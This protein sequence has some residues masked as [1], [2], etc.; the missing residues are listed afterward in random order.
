M[1]RR[2]PVIALLGLLTGCGA[3]ETQWIS[4]TGSP[5]VAGVVRPSGLTPATG[6]GLRG[7]L[8]GTNRDFYLVD[9]RSATPYRLE[10]DDRDALQMLVGELVDA[11]GDRTAASS[12]GMQQFIVRELT[13]VAD[14]CPAE[15]AGA[16]N[17]FTRP[18]GAE[19]G[20]KEV[21]P[22]HAPLGAQ[23]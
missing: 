14:T 8:T 4:M 15:L 19:V 6:N 10:A 20:V 17:Q 21:V 11:T 9:S 13:K 12:S 1:P 16:V 2:I 3:H 23:P 18:G 5:A 22:L 7:C